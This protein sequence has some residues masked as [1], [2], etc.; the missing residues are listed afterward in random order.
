MQTALVIIAISLAFAYLAW[1]F[2]VRFF[3][4]ETKCESCA[5]GNSGEKPMS[6]D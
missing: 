4:K 1:Q 6:N 5:F 3:K 2:F